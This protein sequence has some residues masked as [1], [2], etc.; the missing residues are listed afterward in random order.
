MAGVYA[1]RSPDHDTV[2]LLA[3]NDG[4]ELSL[5][6]AVHTDRHLHALGF[7]RS[8]STSIAGFSLALAG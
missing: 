7:P 2:E 5:L 3:V 4:N 6:L 1:N 8:L